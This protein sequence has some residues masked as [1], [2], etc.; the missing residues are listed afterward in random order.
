VLLYD[1]RVVYTYEKSRKPQWRLNAAS[2][3]ARQVSQSGCHGGRASVAVAASLAQSALA[4]YNQ[5]V[6]VL[7][8]V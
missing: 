3:A 2:A 6:K 1:I 7:F 4:Q 5:E 8:C